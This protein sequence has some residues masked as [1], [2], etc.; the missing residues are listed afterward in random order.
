MSVFSK[1]EK[2]KILEF[3][4]TH[5]LVSRFYL[6]SV[7]IGCKQTIGDLIGGND[8]REIPKW[9]YAVKDFATGK[10]VSNIE[11]NLKDA[12]DFLQYIRES[13]N[14]EKCY[15]TFYDHL[16]TLEKLKKEFKK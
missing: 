14:E 2:K 6:I 5:N 8:K 10:I 16:E 1:E 9:Q 13:H 7:D 3:S 15:V 11:E 4:E 12:L